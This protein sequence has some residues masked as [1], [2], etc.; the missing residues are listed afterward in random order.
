MYVMY[1]MQILLLSNHLIS[2]VQ[3]SKPL[4]PRMMWLFEN[5]NFSLKNNLKSFRFHEKNVFSCGEKL[6]MWIQLN[7]E[8]TNNTKYVSLECSSW[9]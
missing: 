2:S 9:E 5:M 8:K 1:I 7:I 3:L 4:G 6:K